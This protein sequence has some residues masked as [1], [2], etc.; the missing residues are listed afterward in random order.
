M[1]QRGR[2]NHGAKGDAAA[3]LTERKRTVMSHRGMGLVLYFANDSGNMPKKYVE[4]IPH[5]SRTANTGTGG[6]E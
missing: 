3:V 2:R 6:M 4:F 1:Q 5:E